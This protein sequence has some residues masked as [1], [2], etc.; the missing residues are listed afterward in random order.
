MEGHLG[1]DEV[2]AEA[3]LT[4]KCMEVPVSRVFSQSSRFCSYGGQTTIREEKCKE[5]VLG[6]FASH[7]EGPYENLRDAQ[8]LCPFCTRFQEVSVPPNPAYGE[9][10]KRSVERGAH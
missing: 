7:P 10:A 2:T 5:F 9:Q 1:S 8:L 3:W 6:Q 4:Y